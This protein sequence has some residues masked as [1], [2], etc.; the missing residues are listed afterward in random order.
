VRP[1]LA[2][3]TVALLAACSAGPP[4]APAPTA[5]S[6]T[7]ESARTTTPT[8]TP[9]ALPWGPTRADLD[10]AHTA[11]AG[12]SAE[13]LAGQVVVARYAGSDPG[14]AAGLVR[15]HHLAGVILM[16]ENVAGV[17]QVRATAEAVEEAVAADGRGW[18]AVV[19]VDQEGG[20][21]AR[22]GA[23]ATEFPTF[24]SLGA[25]RDAALTRAASAASGAELR[26][27]GFTMVFAPDADVTSGADDP[28]IGSRSAS[29]DPQ[30]VARTVTAAVD[31]YRDAGIVAVAKHY[32]GHG[33]VPADSH[34]TL[35]VQRLSD[36]RLRERDL[37]PFGAAASA[38]VP[39]V[40]VGH[41]AVE[42]WD[43]G[44]PASLSPTAYTRLREQTGFDGVAV[45][46][47]LDM[48]AVTAGAGPGRAAVRALAAGADLLLMP[49]DTAAAVA[50]LATAISNGTLPR[51]RAEE[52]AAR[53]VA[54][55]RWQ[56]RA[57]TAPKDAV[58]A[59]AEQ[60]LAVSRA[61][62][63]VAT[64]PCEK[65]LVGDAVR[66]VGGT[67][68]DRQ[69]F[70]AAAAA[71]GLT[72]GSGDVV[73]LLGRPT[74]AG[75]GDVVVALDAPYGLGRSAATTARLALYGRTPQA[76]H[77]LVEV[78]LGK[79]AATGRLPV[80]VDGL[81]AEAGCPR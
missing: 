10:A 50:A 31:G 64:G 33:S 79:A 81:P 58:G 47:A 8:P 68:T 53:V 75:S 70:T 14:V 22:V 43:A 34:Q 71:A 15:Q 25:A 69:R 78:L 36:A 12:M 67:E 45:T 62:L 74:A 55:M 21:V 17:D 65:R 52:A 63:T 5:S 42:A 11:V 61:A 3:A 72:T 7:A 6:S 49:A 80:H 77:A 19:A 73:R 35:P 48:A 9:A 32:P 4:A 44:Q 39:A 54:L 76:F 29:D 20:Q 26:S 37:V 56:S 40:M 2:A 1:L 16:G 18:P 46:D 27:L 13:Q 28:T 57:A 24:M 59:H 60:S 41:L 51:T 38:G 23:P 66:V 30:L